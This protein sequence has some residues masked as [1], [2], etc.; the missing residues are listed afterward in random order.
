MTDMETKSLKGIQIRQPRAER[1]AALGIGCSIPRALKGHYKKSELPVSVEP[2]QGSARGMF[3][4]R[5]ALRSALGYRM[6]KPF[7]LS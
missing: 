5:A 1:S 6:Y 2:L 7:R 3:S 4:P